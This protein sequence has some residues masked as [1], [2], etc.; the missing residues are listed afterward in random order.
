MK[1]LFIALGSMFLQQSFVTIGKVLPGV[2]APAIVSDLHIEPSWLGVYV[3]IIAAVSLTVQ[4]GCGSVIAR[5]GA[6]RVSQISLLLTGV[7]L[8][9]AAPGLV[10]L[11]VL[12]AA[13]I[14][15]SASSTPASSHLLG[16]YSP[17]KYAPLVFSIKQTAVP[18]GLLTAGLAGPL[19]TENYG[20]QTALL[21]I[22]ACC[23]IFTLFLGLMRN[24]FDNDRDINRKFHLS[25][26]KG[27][28]SLVLRTNELRGL[29]FGSFAF[30]GLQATFTAYFVIY[31]TDIGYSLIEAGTIFSI[32]TA[33]AI[34]GR[35]LWGWL[36]SGYINPR[37][38][39]G[40]LALLMF[41]AVALTSS[42]DSSWAA[43]QITLVAIGVS[44]TVFSWHGVT[45]AEA[46][47]L[48]PDSMRGAVTGGVLSFGQCGGLVLPL[49]YSALFGLTESY[50]LG[51]LVCAVPALFV[52]S[53]LLYSARH[54]LWMRQG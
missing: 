6:L 19:L 46:A 34:P 48:A 9:L 45:L 37:A 40:L 31:L 14:G 7:G 8:A 5:Y 29:A 22:S 39:L 35:I 27:T 53:G 20:W 51:F 25:D 10:G 32:A 12:S 11:M 28:I 2:L 54:R 26:F 3:G 38:M 23:V 47:R 21:V 41:L 30:V 52:G 43:W 13:A 15:A 50:Q 44:I 4:A 17:P 16:R 42:F 33:V 24:E 36:S 18:V 1:W 49:T